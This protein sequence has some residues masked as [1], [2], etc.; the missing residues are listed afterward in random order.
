MTTRQP[1]PASSSRVIRMRPIVCPARRMLVDE[2]GD[3]PARR[4]DGATG[5]AHVVERRPYELRGET[6]TAHRPLDLGVVEGRRVTGQAI[7]GDADHAS[8]DD[9]LVAGPLCVVSR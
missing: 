8:I 6:L 1:A 3:V 4:D 9:Q 2:L 5:V 7:V